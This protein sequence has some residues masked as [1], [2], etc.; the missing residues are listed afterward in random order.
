M[1]VVGLK[2]SEMEAIEEFKDILLRTFTDNIEMIKLYGSKRRGDY[3]PESDIDLF[4][5][6]ENGDWKLRDKMV[7]VS[8]DL[9]LKYEVLISPSVVNKEEYEKMKKLELRYL[10]EIEEGIDIWKKKH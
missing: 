7:D 6:V 8:S 1:P 5:L 10:K 3:H 4:I 9:L 2:R